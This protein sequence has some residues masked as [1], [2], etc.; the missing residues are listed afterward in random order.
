MLRVTCCLALPCIIVIDDNSDSDSDSD[1][2][3]K[4]D[5]RHYAG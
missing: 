3:S 1:S 2:D 5:S 4:N